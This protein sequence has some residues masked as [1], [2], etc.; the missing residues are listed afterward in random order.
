MKLDFSITRNKAGK[1]MMGV[2][3]P[4]WYWYL[5]LKSNNLPL[6][7]FIFLMLDLIVPEKNCTDAKLMQIRCHTELVT[8][9]IIPE[10]TVSDT[11]SE[12]V[13]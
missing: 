9:E 13:K 10:T 4:K 6:S 12:E 8:S 3:S 5:P 11:G 1:A 2:Q 7:L